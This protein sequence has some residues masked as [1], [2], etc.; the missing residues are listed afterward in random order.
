[1]QISKI[2]KTENLKL[3][4]EQQN[5]YNSV[6]SAMQERRYNQ[7]LLYGVT[8]SGKT[9]VYLQLIGEVLKRNKTA[10]VLVPEYH[11]LHR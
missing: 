4:D 10:I 7:F 2:A 3:T 8:G 6:M 9:E 1:M 5:A 11:L